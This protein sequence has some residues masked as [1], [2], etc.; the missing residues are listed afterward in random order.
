MAGKKGAKHK[1]SGAERFFRYKTVKEKFSSIE[2]LTY[3][4]ITQ[5]DDFFKRNEK[6]RPWHID[7]LIAFVE[8]NLTDYHDRFEKLRALSPRSL[9]YFIMRHGEEEGIKRHAA[10]R[11]Q[12]VLNQDN[13][14]EYWLEKGFAE[15]EAVRKAKDRNIERGRK[16]GKMLKG[17]GDA[18]RRCVKWWTN[19]GY[20]VADAKEEIKQIQVQNGLTW[21]LSKYGD[22]GVERYQARIE[23]WKTKMQQTMIDLGYWKSDDQLDHFEQY[24]KD[25]GRETERNYREFKHIIN[26]KDLPRDGKSFELDHRYSKMQGFIEKIPPEVIGHWVNLEMLP[27]EENNSK[28]ISCSIEKDDLFEAYSR[29]KIDQ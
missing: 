2:D 22:S 17:R 12:A 4:Q 27:A 24:M 28:W 20:S 10:V 8:G 25:V 7:T 11:E 19:R 5:L 14:P 23:S 29:A 18:S 16:S 21:Y 1:A 3:Y 9:E 26:P 6:F 13:Q 15:Q